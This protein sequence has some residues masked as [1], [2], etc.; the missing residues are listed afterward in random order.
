MMKYI[1][2]NLD[3]YIINQR[4]TV[5]NALM[6]INRNRSKGVYI[7]NDDQQLTAVLT[8]GDIRRLILNGVSVSVCV[9]DVCNRAVKY[10]QLKS[11]QDLKEICEEMLRVYTDISSIPVVDNEMRILFIA[12]IAN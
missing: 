12:N 8:D 9:A 3:L 6:K 5:Y 10:V 2:T 1:K 7:V 4:E 11:D